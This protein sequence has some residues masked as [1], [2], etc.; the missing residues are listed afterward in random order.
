MATYEIDGVRPVIRPTAFVHPEAV[1]IG[2]VIVEDGCYVGPLASL[3]GDFGRIVVGAGSNVQD[4]CV[5]HS[6]PGADCV[7]EPESHIGHGAILHGCTVRSLAMIGMNSVLMDGVDV[8][9]HALVAANSFLP[10][11]F[12]V[13]DQSLVAGNPAKI[14][15]QLDET[16]LAWKANGV[17]VY[18]QL[19]QRSLASLRPC[20]PLHEVEDDRQRVSTGSDVSRPLAEYRRGAERS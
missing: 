6:F 4:G 8:G 5:L 15:R 11:E 18:Q 9:R 7:L 1:L 19:A 2:D 13:P 14:I 10:A 17:K 12:V 20:E 16:T 3:R